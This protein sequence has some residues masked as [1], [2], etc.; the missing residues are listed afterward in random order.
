VDLEGELFERGG[1]LVL[2][3]GSQELWRAVFSPDPTL[4]REHVVCGVFPPSVL[5]QLRVGDAL[6]FAWEPPAGFDL[7]PVRVTAKVS[8]DERLARELAELA[9]WAAAPDDP[10]AARLRAEVLLRHDHH[11]GAWFEALAA[12]EAGDA[13]TRAVHVLRRVLERVEAIG[14]LLLEL[15]GHVA[16]GR[17]RPPL[18]SAPR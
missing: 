1:E 11:A 17:A 12:I 4:A 16:Y 3:R 13:G 10:L 2:R 15:D 8:D 6:T 9:R 5:E 14:P 7:T 18:C